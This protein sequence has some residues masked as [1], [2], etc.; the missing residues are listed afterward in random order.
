MFLQYL[1]EQ[2]EWI[3]SGVGITILLAV[4]KIF[5]MILTTIFRGYRLKRTSKSDFSAAYPIPISDLYFSENEDENEPTQSFY[6]N[7]SIKTHSLILKQLKRELLNYKSLVWIDIDKFTQINNTFGKEIGDMIINTILKILYVLSKR[8]NCTIYHAVKRDEFYIIVSELDLRDCA[9]QF[10]ALIEQYEWSKII[11]GL[12]IT[13]SAG[14][15]PNRSRHPIDTIKK[16]RV[17]LDLIKS[18]GGNGIGPQIY[19]LHPYQLVNLKS[20]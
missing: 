16:A 14:I 17:S 13:C 2:K 8:Y 15:A 9:Q 12:Y 7:C 4:Y 10:M 1:S 19:K 3:F 20:S 5:K 18:Q 11:P 6:K